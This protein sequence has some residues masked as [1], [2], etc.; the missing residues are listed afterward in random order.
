MA[1]TPVR[2]ANVRIPRYRADHGSCMALGASLRD[3]GQRHPI[4]L[5]RDGTLIS[6]ERRVFAAMLLGIDRL[7]AVYVGTIEEAAKRLFADNQDSH[8]AMPPKWSEVCKL[9]QTLRRLDEPAAVRRADENRRRG[10][11]LRRQTQAGARE[12]GRSHKRTDDYVL[13]VV[14]EPF[15]VSVATATRAEYI[16][17]VATGLIEVTGEKR[18]LAKKLLAD[19]DGGAPVWPA[20]QQL[21]GDE[22]AARPQRIRRPPAPTDPAPAAKQLAAWARAIPQMEGLMAG[23]VELGP[24]HPDLTWDQVGPVHASLAAIRREMEKIIKKMRE[25]EK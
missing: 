2:L 16:Y 24:P 8:L 3:E 4:A 10:V 15:G 14:C 25:I 21:R 19:L 12:P 17:R 5:W 22:L 9:W 11:E 6:G 23:L 18:E 13:T 1:E 20:H 7:N